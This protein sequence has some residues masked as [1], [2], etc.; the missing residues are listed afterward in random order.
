MSTPIASRPFAIL[1]LATLFVA[2]LALAGCPPA[3]IAPP[4]GQCSDTQP[5]ANGQVCAD[6]ACVQ[7][8][9]P[10][11]CATG[12]CNPASGL[13]VECIDD[14]DCGAERLCN[15]FTNLCQQPVPGC[16]DDSDCDG[17][18]L[19]D[20]I[21]GSCVGC[22]DNGDCG[23]GQ[24]CDQIT[25]ECVSQAGC[26]TDG[27]CAGAVCEP[28]DRVCVECF[29]GAHCASGQCDSVSNTCLSGCSDDDDTEPNSAAE[30]GNAAPLTSGSEHNG[31]VCPGDVDEFSFTGAGTVDAALTVDGGRLVIELQNGAGTVIATGSTGVSSSGLAQGNYKLVVR[32][33]DEAVEADYRLTLTITAPVVCEELDSEPNDNAGA[34]LQ[35]PTDGN[36]RGG[37]ICNGGV[38]FWRFNVSAGDDVIV[39]VTDGEGTGV[40]TA[41]VLSGATV[42]D[43]ASDGNDAAV[44]NAAAGTLN[45]RVQARGGDSSYTLRVTTSA[46]P[47]QCVQ[48]DAEPNNTAADARPLTAATQTGQICAADVDQWRFTTNNLDDVTITLAGSNVRARLFTDGG[49]V[50]G[51]GTTT[52]TVEDV[53]AGVHRV[54]VRGTNS[55]V[56]A[57]YTVTVNVTPEPQDDPCDEAGLEPDSRTAPRPLTT[58]GAPLGGRICAADS[59]FFRFSVAGGTQLVAVSTR[60]VD[61]DGDLDVRLLD[62]AGALVVASTGVSDEEL[63]QRELAAGTYTLEV[64]G[65]QGAANTYTVSAQILTCTDDNFEPNDA[66][67]SSL[68]ISGRA[69]SGVRCPQN[70]D[71]YG[72][73]LENGDSLDARL[74]GSGLTMSL[75][76]TTGS[77]VQADS[78][79]GSNR[80]LQVSGIAAGNYALRV[81]GGGA[82][83]VAYTLTPTVTPSPSRCV[84]DG[85]EPNNAS[86][87]AFTLNAQNLADGSY[88]LNTV[89]MCDGSNDFFAIDLP[90]QKSVRVF[91]Q[92]AATS[93]LDIELL[94]Q[95]GT[96]GLFRSIARAVSL[97][98]TLDEVGG[99]MNA[100][101]RVVVRVAE[102]GTMPTGGLPYTLGFEVSDP[103][104]QP[105]VDDRFDTWT[106]TDDGVTRTHTND[107]DADPN[108]SDNILVA[109]VDLSA[110]ETL[111]TLRICPNNS[112]FYRV[113]VAA[114]QRLNVD[115]T[116]THSS[117]RD[118]D[119]RVFEQGVATALT[120]PGLNCTGTDGTEHFDVTP[121]AAKTYFIEVFGFLGSENEYTLAVSN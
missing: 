16:V 110:P 63:I 87:V 84:D 67:S 71:F 44:D 23:G 40:V 19:C 111:P 15:T 9:T 76:S 41:D 106:S 10:T 89:N 17:G 107:D 31:S 53:A 43:S 21:K 58:D 99:Q 66:A 121:T 98:G 6:G 88:E 49:A 11:S 54:E 103:P 94:E 68:P 38:D 79:D 13:C 52:F 61:A 97:T 105:C 20:T 102:F 70:D 47:V 24:A 77:V 108:T 109:P 25:R 22:L 29:T 51:E 45:V 65:F 56:E 118:I 83:G 80:R 4:G 114:N 120:C 46:A 12:F 104:N 14:D 42:L 72:V 60:F 55:T 90:G 7:P 59:D 2:V 86:D 5:C 33:L 95:R 75:V 37:S 50:L 36:V 117:S 82:G 119:I 91:L 93:D 64:F 35:M 92:H 112:D 8:C 113:S 101:T 96:S 1:P 74:T 3:D 48:T 62:G 26:V 116:Y 32:G 18:Q 27:D 34:A 57:G 30:A 39:S 73:R 81:T 78:A 115:V 85:A 69:V 28:T 100:G